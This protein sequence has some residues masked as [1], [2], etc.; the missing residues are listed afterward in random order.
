MFH[1][2]RS[3]RGRVASH[4]VQPVRN[5]AYHEGRV[6]HYSRGSGREGVCVSLGRGPALD[7]VCIDLSDETRPVQLVSRTGRASVSA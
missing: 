6:W 2:Y 1:G 7:I 3:A 4:S 5:G